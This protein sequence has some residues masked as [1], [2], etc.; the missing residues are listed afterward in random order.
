MLKS[1]LKASKRA[2]GGWPQAG[3]GAPLAWNIVLL[4][5][6]SVQ[7]G[8]PKLV[9]VIR[10]AGRPWLL[11]GQLTDRNICQALRS[12]S[13][14]TCGNWPAF[15]SLVLAAIS[16]SPRNCGARIGAKFGKLATEACIAA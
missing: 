3:G 9:S 1:R 7:R 8:A 15:S 13:R 4:L 5:C 2:A 14:C 12:N 11:V 10:S 6:H 16:T